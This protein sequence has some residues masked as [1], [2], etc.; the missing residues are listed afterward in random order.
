MG[1]LRPKELTRLSPP[2]NQL[3]SDFPDGENGLV[4][5]V[6]AS[7]RRSWIVRYRTVT[8]FRRGFALGPYPAVGLSEARMRA[9]EIC[10]AAARGD[11]PALERTQAKR[12]AEDAKSDPRPQT[13]DALFEAYLVAAR[14]GRHKARARIKRETSLDLETSRWRNHIAP[15]FGSRAPRDVSRGDIRRWLD[16]LAGS[17][18]SPAGING[19]GAVLRLVMSYG[20]YTDLIEANPALGVATPFEVESR[21]R[22]LTQKEL[23]RVWTALVAEQPIKME[24]GT[25][26][27]LALAATTLQ[28]LGDVCKLR[29]SQIDDAARTWSIPAD[30]I[31]GGR[32]HVVPLSKLA[33]NLIARARRF[34]NAGDDL[35]FPG[36]TGDRP[37]DRRAATRSYARLMKHLEIDDAKPHDNR[38]TGATMLTGERFGY[39]RFV[40]SKVLD[41]KSDTG[42]AAAVTGVYDRNDYLPEKRRALEDWAGCLERLVPELTPRK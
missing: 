10:A 23:A 27:C 33:L 17:G 18:L 25:A 5:R 9:R 30:Q 28:R 29:I 4:F 22:V 15:T 2:A 34:P 40:V 3:R 42:G 7:G 11:D 38:R 12:M 26:L 1:R 39:S 24:P 35:V 19:C 21:T 31:K 37:L 36:R 8:G 13:M 16:K 41:H 32:L 6:A 20:V 14:A